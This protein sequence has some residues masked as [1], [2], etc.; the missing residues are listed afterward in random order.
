MTTWTEI[1]ASLPDAE[2]QVRNIRPNIP[3]NPDMETRMLISEAYASGIASLSRDISRPRL[4]PDA[5]EDCVHVLLEYFIRGQAF[6]VNRTM[7][8]PEPTPPTEPAPTQTPNPKFKVKEPDTF[9][10][11]RGKLD[12][13]LRQLQTYFHLF[14]TAFQDDSQK[15]FFAGSYLRGNAARWFEPY[16][17]DFGKPDQHEETTELFHN[18]DN[19]A[20]A[21]RETFEDK[22]QYQDAA[23]R[24]QTLK[25]T[26][27][28]ATYTTQFRL[29]AS[30]LQWPDNVLKMLYY[31][32]LKDHIK[33]EFARTKL[34]DSYQEVV[35]IAIQLDTRL[36]DRRREATRSNRPAANSSQPRNT[37]SPG[38]PMD[39]DSVRRN[40]P[41]SQ[42]EKD[43]R[44][45]ED[46]C[47]RCGKKGHYARQCKGGN[48]TTRQTSATQVTE[49]EDSHDKQHWA[50]CTNDEC[51]SHREP[52][53]THGYWPEA[54]N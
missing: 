1:R 22:D 26:G 19:F 47:L 13:F 29:Y 40:G 28:A 12:E 52:K 6:T 39:L 48:K 3:G 44:R 32:G 8:I 41:L 42:E 2:D 21:L 18:F 24:I 27:S 33:D 15:I 16:Q 45:K 50:D 36:Y 25:Q 9:D 31:E 14:G 11:T 46:L 20:K 7:R 43:R 49:V 5:S 23:H 35:R 30:R 54:K 34:P 10:G 4:P 17:E 38:E 37:T 53:E 51:E